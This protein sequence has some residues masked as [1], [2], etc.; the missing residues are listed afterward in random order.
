MDSI[1]SV[2][3][4]GKTPSRQGELSEHNAQWGSDSSEKRG[5]E[6]G[7][8][9]NVSDGSAI[10]KVLARHSGAPERTLSVRRVPHLSRKACLAYPC[11]KSEVLSHL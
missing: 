11:L 4:M 3:K 7:L 6:T 2:G 5:E 10:L 9:E 1:T 8:G